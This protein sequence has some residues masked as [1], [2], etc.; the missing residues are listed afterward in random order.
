MLELWL[1]LLGYGL[2]VAIF[3]TLWQRFLRRKDEEWRLF[4]SFANHH[5]FE[6]IAYT[7]IFIATLTNATARSHVNKSMQQLLPTW[8][9]TV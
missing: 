4:G 9:S 5:F 8:T 3:A 1:E 2:L 6:L 7:I